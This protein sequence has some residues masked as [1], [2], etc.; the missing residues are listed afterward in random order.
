[1]AL[2]QMIKGGGNP[3]QLIGQMIQQNPQIGQ[4]M[5]LL[6]GKT[7]QQQMQVLRNMAQERGVDLGRLARQIGLPWN[8]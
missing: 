7:Q 5:R 6:E 1:M 8:D 2:V 3:Q 4:A